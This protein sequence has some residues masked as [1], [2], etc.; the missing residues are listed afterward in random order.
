MDD[1]AAC[2]AEA[3]VGVLREKV[4]NPVEGYFLEMVRMV[5]PTTVTPTRGTSVQTERDG[6][7]VCH[8]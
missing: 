7:L 8:K 5:W 3:G 1:C 6:C 2:H 4:K